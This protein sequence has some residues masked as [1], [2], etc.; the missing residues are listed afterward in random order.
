M[1]TAAPLFYKN[2]QPITPEKHGSQFLRAP[3]G[4]EFAS[5]TN[6][7]PL[8]A[9]EFYASAK[10]FPIVFTATE[11][12]IPVAL[13]GL[14]DSRN[15]FVK[16]GQWTAGYIP[17]YVRRYPFVL[18]TTPEPDKLTLCI[19]E[20]SNFLSPDA[21]GQAL[22]ESSGEPSPFLKEA[23]NFCGQYQTHWQV[24]NRF[25]QAVQA[26]DL[27]VPKYANITTPTDEK[28]T[29]GGFLVID[30]EKFNALSDETFLTWR[31]EGWLA[32]V[33]AHFFSQ[34][35]WQTLLTAFSQVKQN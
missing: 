10:F 19:D 3:S 33:Y 5:S 12:P 25:V 13:L 26:A 24:T 9:T 34:S 8:A 35:N 6:S 4:F 1:T 22:F 15:V 30:E 16:E 17:A 2:P 7:V 23:L 20:G 18:A 32:L 31:K 21:N 27:L 28:L 14:E 29:L 11:T